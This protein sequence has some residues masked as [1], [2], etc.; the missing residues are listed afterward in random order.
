MSILPSSENF[1]RSGQPT[2]LFLTNVFYSRKSFHESK[3]PTIVMVIII[4]EYTFLCVNKKT[5]Y[6]VLKPLL[7]V[8]D[9]KYCRAKSVSEY[10][11]MEQLKFP[12]SNVSIGAI[13]FFIEFSFDLG[14]GVWYC[15]NIV[16]KRKQIKKAAG[17][18]RRRW[19]KQIKRFD[20]ISSSWA[21]WRWLVFWLAGRLPP[22]LP[23]LIRST[24][25]LF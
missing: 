18:L 5:C 10:F 16:S 13:F 4:L 12:G 23:M 1:S 11:F 7:A 8:S 19:Q 17:L 25:C 20:G 22:R 21:D 9:Y 24:P 3:S 14:F 2:L 15:S 6:A